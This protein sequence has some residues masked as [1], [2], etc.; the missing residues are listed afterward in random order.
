[1]PHKFRLT[2]QIQKDLR[3]IELACKAIQR[4]KISAI[5]RKEAWHHFLRY[6]EMLE[7]LSPSKKEL[8]R[9]ITAY[10][11][12][13]AWVE[14][15]TPISEEKIKLLHAI[16]LG[17]KRPTRYRKGQNG[18]LDPVTYEV[19]Y[20]PPKAKDVPFLMKSLVAWIN[21]A[22]YPCPVVA[23]IAH[24]GINSIH[25]FYD[26]NGRCARLLTKWIVM[27]GG[28]DLEG[29]LCLEEY[30]AKDLN[31]YY[32]ALTIG[33]SSN[34]YEGPANHDISSWLGYFCKGMAYSCQRALQAR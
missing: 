32:N 11:Q 8:K 16:I 30:Y 17:N 27:R 22:A 21:Q 3:K 19:L 24:F 20:Y 28:F 1:M 23:A 18:V 33:H 12:I 9:Y 6:F 31:A 2:P 25:P 14:S 15:K 34:Y 26:G 29:L 7:E 10:T 5:A 13:V 4:Q